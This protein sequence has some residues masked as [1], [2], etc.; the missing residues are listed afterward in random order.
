MTP[1]TSA[2][3]VCCSSDFA[4]LG[5]QARILDGDHRLIGEA[6]QQLQLGRLEGLQHVAVNDQRADGAAAGPQRRADHGANAGAARHWWA[7]PIREFGVEAVE[8]G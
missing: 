5:E 8:I 3:A 2:V 6:L 1:S 4:Q 7:G